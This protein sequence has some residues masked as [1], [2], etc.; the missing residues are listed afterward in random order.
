MTEG[1][2]G[3]RLIAGWAAGGMAALAWLL[4]ELAGRLGSRIVAALVAIPAAVGL[5]ALLFIAASAV[6]DLT[7]ILTRKQDNHS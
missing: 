2:R 5:L 3:F 6:M 1:R 4:T 7:G